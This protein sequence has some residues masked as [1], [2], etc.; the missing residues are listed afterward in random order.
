[1]KEQVLRIEN[2]KCFK[3][4]EIKFPSLTVLVGTNGMGKSTVI[5]SLLLMRCAKEAE[6]GIIK[7]N[8]PYGLALGTNESVINQNAIINHIDFTLSELSGEKLAEFRLKGDSKVEKLELELANK[9]GGVF[10]NKGLFAEEFYF[11]SAERTG[12]RIAQLLKPQSF[13][14]TGPY[15]EYTGQILSDKYYK[16]QKERQHTSKGNPYIP[17]QTNAWMNEILPGVE[18]MAERS[19]SMQ[20]CQ[21]RIRNGFTRDYVESTNIGFGISYSLPIVIQGLIAKRGCYFIV[22]NPEAHLHPAA[23]TEMG[24]FLAMLAEKGL[25]VIIETHS[26]HL[27]DGIQLY[28]ATHLQMAKDVI[29][30]H[31]G[32]DQYRRP[33]I[34]P[35]KYDSQLDY[36]C[37]PKGFMD[38]TSINYSNLTDMI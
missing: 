30:Y 21:V 31:F 11:L 29:I 9:Y 1:M 13:V 26:D 3:H 20:V 36:S 10:T 27:L 19:T 6:K 22:E 15:G 17:A 23:Q 33:E 38:Q 34:N 24:K 37:W 4:L 18:V 16:I 25:R 2:F 12:P 32:I 28:L 5:Q 35:I 7:L 14:H 8:G